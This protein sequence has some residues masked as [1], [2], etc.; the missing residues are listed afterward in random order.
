[1]FHNVDLIMDGVMDIHA[2]LDLILNCSKEK[3][4]VTILMGIMF[5]HVLVKL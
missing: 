5:V 4:P 3:P 1:M 2:Q